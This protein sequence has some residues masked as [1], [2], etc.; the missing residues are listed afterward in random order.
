MKRLSVLLVLLAWPASAQQPSP[1]VTHTLQLSDQQINGIIE[2]GA[3][4]LD[5][6]PYACARYALYMHDLLQQARQPKPEPKKDP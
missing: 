1:Q 5:K 3:A 4:C 2:V 6:V